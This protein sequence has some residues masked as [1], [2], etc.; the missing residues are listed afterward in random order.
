MAANIVLQHIPKIE[1]LS[2]R[3][4]RILGCNP[5]PMTLQGTNTYLVGTGKKRILVDTGDADV[6]EYVESLQETL[7]KFD[8]SIQE[9]ILTHYHHDHVGGIANIWKDVLNGGSPSVKLSKYSL[10]DGERV[11]GLTEASY[12]FIN[13]GHVFNTEGATLH[14]L[15][16]PGHTSDHICLH[17][18]EENVLL[19]GDNI[20]GQGTA[21]FEDLY[22]YMKSLERM[23]RV[24]PA[25]IY[26]SHGPVVEEPTK[27]ITE[28]I[29]HRNLRESQVLETINAD[30]AKEHTTLSLVESIYTGL[31]ENLIP[32]AQVNVSHHLQ[33]LVKEG[34][35]VQGDNGSTFKSK[36]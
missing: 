15:Y 16:T 33:K 18:Q 19:S 13:D 1:Q 2:A 36:L 14:A 4:I 7:K 26:P 8:C 28:Y 27:K 10:T 29:A 22:D 5:S 25:K 30:V 17:L 31:A 12:T 24:E 23:L 20:L 3:V 11:P 34:K 6:P 32:V 21:V 9:I 35:I